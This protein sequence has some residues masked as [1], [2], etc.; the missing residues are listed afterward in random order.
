MA[1][2]HDATHLDLTIMVNNS[3]TTFIS[4]H[5]LCAMFAFQPSS[6]HISKDVLYDSNDWFRIHYTRFLPPPLK[7]TSWSLVMAN[8]ALLVK[9][10][11]QFLRHH[12]HARNHRF[13][14]QDCERWPWSSW[15][16]PSMFKCSF[17]LEPYS[18]ASSIQL[19]VSCLRAIAL[20]THTS[21]ELRNLDYNKISLQKIQFLLIAFDGNVFFELPPVFLT[22]HRPSQM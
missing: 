19:V 17:I 2:F 11:S 6:L 20:P 1:T 15:H 9:F 18:L 12:S 3:R 4:K 7:V 5:Y 16:S 10:E 8:I 14:C 22:M 13:Y 21:N